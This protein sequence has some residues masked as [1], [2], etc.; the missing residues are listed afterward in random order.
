M[1]ELDDGVMVFN[2]DGRLIFANESAVRVTGDQDRKA[3]RLDALSPRLLE[4][5]GTVVPLWS[6]ETRLGDLVLLPRSAQP[7]TLAERERDAIMD[8]LR[9]T[10]GRLTETARALGVSRTTLWRRLRSYGN[11]NGSPAG[12][13][14]AHA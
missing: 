7:A 12:N 11:G 3:K 8:A 10:G 6:G 1:R 2:T 14:A 4:L 9:R 5:G 13:G